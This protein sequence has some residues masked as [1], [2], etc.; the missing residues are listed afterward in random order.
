M[1]TNCC[2]VVPERRGRP[3]QPERQVRV[4]T[5]WGSRTGVKMG[6]VCELCQ[7]PVIMVCDKKILI[8]LGKGVGIDGTGLGRIESTLALFS[9]SA[10][11]VGKGYSH[12]DAVR[13]S[14]F[15]TSSFPLCQILLEAS[16]SQ[17][18]ILRILNYNVCSAHVAHIQ[19]RT[20]HCT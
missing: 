15:H 6:M 20:V 17:G 11:P 19:S 5:P 4:A 13:V 3:V 2:R 7:H 16:N 1:L 14:I 18:L 9:A 10:L 12:A 8:K